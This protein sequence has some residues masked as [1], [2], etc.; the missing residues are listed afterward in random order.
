MLRCP[1][2]FE[3][4][5]SDKGQGGLLAG[6]VWKQRHKSGLSSV[7]RPPHPRQKKKITSSQNLKVWPYLEI[8]SLQMQ[9]GKVN[10]IT[11]VR[12]GHA[13]LGQALNPMTSVS[14]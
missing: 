13:R 1:V 8:G 4:D 6:S 7:P 14:L 3:E 11:Q 5:G 2:L 10:V 9:L 12:W